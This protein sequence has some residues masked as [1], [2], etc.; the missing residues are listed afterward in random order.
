[1]PSLVT[2]SAAV[3]AVLSVVTADLCASGAVLEKGNYYCQPVKKIQYSRVSSSG[4]Y[5][6]VIDMSN[7]GGCLYEPA[8][9]SGSLAP[10]NE[11]LSLHVRGPIEIKSI[12][13]YKPKKAAPKHKRHTH[14]RLHKRDHEIVENIEKREELEKRDMVTAV[15]NGQTVSWVNNY[16]GPT[17]AAGTAGQAPGRAPAPAQAPPAARPS[18][19]EPAVELAPGDWVRE[20]HYDADTG[21]ADGFVFLS[22]N[23]GQGSGV[24]DTVFGNSL[25]YANA[26]GLAGCAKPEVLK[27]TVLP[28]NKEIAIFS[29]K[30]CNGDCGY[31]R[32]GSVAYHGFAGCDKAFLVEF[33]MPYDGNTGFN[34]DMPALWFLN[35]QIPRTVQYGKCSCWQSN[36]GEFDAFEVLDSGNSK[37]KSTLHSV[38]PGGCSDYFAR[39]AVNFMKA[40]IVFHGDYI[41]IQ[42]LDDDVKFG[43][44]ISSSTLQGICAAGGVAEGL[45]SSFTLA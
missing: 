7:D 29:D 20:A 27:K 18:R 21:V 31:V 39:P 41:T 38:R 25:S 17:P 14:E 16:F 37:C 42:V 33:K 15:I 4:T 6:R 45:F 2:L 3:A 8:P 10:F 34:G 40:A 12:A 32:P 24:F 23:G 5:Q 44:T 43:K 1:M 11:E 13:Y 9:F 30:P 19:E 22:N 36:C 35:A 26:D 28:S